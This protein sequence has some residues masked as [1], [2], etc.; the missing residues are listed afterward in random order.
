L[1]AEK[2][3]T[4]F[5]QGASFWGRRVGISEPLLRGKPSWLNPALAMLDSSAWYSSAPSKALQCVQNA[6]SINNI[7][8]QTIKKKHEKTTTATTTT[9]RAP[10]AAVLLPVVLLLF[11]LG[12]APTTS[13]SILLMY[14][15]F[16]VAGHCSSFCDS[17]CSCCCFLGIQFSQNQS[18]NNQTGNVN[19]QHFILADLVCN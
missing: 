18:D 17:W 13:C 19:C 14:F 15:F 4:T 12:V 10:I 9:T 7:Q 6:Y 5:C 3:T 8:Q 16:L 2:C 1:N 11:F